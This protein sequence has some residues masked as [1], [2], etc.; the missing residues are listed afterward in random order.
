MK[1]TRK[2][3][4][5]ST[6]GPAS[7][8]PEQIEALFK[9]GADVFRLNFSHGTQA[10][11]RRRYDIIRGVE[12]R[13]KRPIGILAD[14]QGPKLRVGNFAAG[15]VHLDNGA[16]LRLDLDPG[17]GQRPAAADGTGDRVGDDLVRIRG[18]LAHRRRSRHGQRAEDG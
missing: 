12:A 2:A 15:K 7:S 6:L 18:P 10:D 17:R 9:A 1:R 5:L 8:T 14:L 11:H 16:T 3:K 13:Y 4:I